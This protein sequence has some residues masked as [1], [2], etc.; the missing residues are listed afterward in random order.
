[1]SGNTSEIGSMRDV[2]ENLRATATSDMLEAMA[3]ELTNHVY[4]VSKFGLSA[5]GELKSRDI[6]M[7]MDRWDLLFRT[8]QPSAPGHEQFKPSNHR[9]PTPARSGPVDMEG[10]AERIARGPTEMRRPG[11]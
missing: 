3:R 9:Q 10:L 6:Q 5:N 4:L 1:M 11:G 2:L 7:V 8:I